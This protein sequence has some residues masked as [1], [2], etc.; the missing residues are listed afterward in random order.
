MPVSY[1]LSPSTFDIPLLPSLCAYRSGHWPIVEILR[2]NCG[3]GPDNWPTCCIVLSV[4]CLRVCR[5]F[6]SLALALVRLGQF[7][8]RQYSGHLLLGLPRL[9]T[10][11]ILHSACMWH[12]VD[13]SCIHGAC[14]SGHIAC[15]CGHVVHRVVRL[16]F[17]SH[18]RWHWL[19]RLLSCGHCYVGRLGASPRAE[20]S[21]WHLL[22]GHVSRY[23]PA[24]T[25][26]GMYL[27]MSPHSPS[28][29][30]YLFRG[31]PFAATGASFLNLI[32]RHI[33]SVRAYFFCSPV[34]NRPSI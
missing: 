22:C 8:A 24:L 13:C 23:V 31:R 5:L 15:A 2:W 16:A 26:P 25:S 33:C 19:W 7:S 20:H 1:L 3:D 17:S 11:R 12:Q 30:V 29:P 27:A 6:F 10:A 34:M 32:A 9:S 4:A 14:N 21:H 18:R 28:L